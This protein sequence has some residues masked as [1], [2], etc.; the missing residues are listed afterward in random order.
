MANRI[1]LQHIFNDIALYHC[2]YNIKF[3]IFSSH[4]VQQANQN[5]FDFMCQTFLMF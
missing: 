2:R 1:A 5:A 3:S 4:F